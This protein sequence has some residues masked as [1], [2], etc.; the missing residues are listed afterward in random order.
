MK[1]YDEIIEKQSDYDA[2]ETA[3]FKVQQALDAAEDDL[4]AI[5]DELLSL[6]D[7]IKDIIKAIGQ[8]HLKSNS[9]LDELIKK[10]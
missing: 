3:S 10:R 8:D 4:G 2:V 7:Q 9:Y 5:E 6:K 1:S